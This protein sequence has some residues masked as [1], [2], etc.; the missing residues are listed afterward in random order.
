MAISHL[1]VE[2]TKLTT[3]AELGFSIK[4]L[5]KTKKKTNKNEPILFC[6]CKL[7]KVEMD[8]HDF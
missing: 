6:K 1:P 2:A 7:E 4:L 3:L 5:M 8:L